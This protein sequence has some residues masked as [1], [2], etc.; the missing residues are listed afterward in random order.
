LR[1]L[2]LQLIKA[3]AN[4]FAIGHFFLVTMITVQFEGYPEDLT[5][6]VAV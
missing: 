3:R 4:Q 5:R 1:Q 2:V 6:R